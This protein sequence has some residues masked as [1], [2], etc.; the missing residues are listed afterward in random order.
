[1]SISIQS[2]L[3]DFSVEITGKDAESFTEA[4][5]LLPE[6]SRVNVT[7]LGNE[8]LQ[9]RRSTSAVVK[10]G[11]HRPVPHIS[12]R[13]VTSHQ[14]LQ[15]F[16]SALHEDGTSAH[17]LVIAGDPSEPMGP[18]EDA[19]AIFKTG[20]ALGDFGVQRVSI[21]GYPE[22]H[23]D[24]PDEV[25]WSALKAKFEILTEQGQEAEIVTQFGF[26]VEA[27]IKWIELLRE[28]GVSLPV[29]VG[30]PGP[31][32]VKRL[33]AYARRFGVAS[34]TGI[35]KKYG[36]SLTNLLSTAGP[37]QFLSHLAERLDPN[38][39]GDVRI[40]FYTFG[41]LQ[42]TAEWVRDFSTTEE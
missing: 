18:Y 13:R 12:A 16:L 40:H 10:A 20:P 22:G 14:E 39:H 23:P 15:E 35:A 38:A 1:M 27:V 32:G 2:L 33:L 41:G 28:S 11:G 17:I 37:D 7:Y 42:R 9:L 3:G 6:G 31:A 8:D 30:V 19:L 4:S 36:L 5:G 34:S 29:R 25:L 24:I 21:S 26:D